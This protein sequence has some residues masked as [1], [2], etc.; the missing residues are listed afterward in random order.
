MPRRPARGRRGGA[1]RGALDP[2]RDDLIGLVVVVAGVLLG[3]AVYLRVAGPVGSGIDT[4]LGAL[5]GV[6]RYVLPAALLACGVAPADN[7]PGPS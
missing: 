5:V 1:V 6:G 3:L 7:G 2:H 4:G